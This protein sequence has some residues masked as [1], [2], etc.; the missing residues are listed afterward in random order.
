M[1]LLDKLGRV[2]GAFDGCHDGFDI[3]GRRVFR[4]RSRPAAP[5]ARAAVDA[6]PAPRMQDVLKGYTRLR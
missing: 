4:P 1:P 3:L 6:T 2:V 5:R